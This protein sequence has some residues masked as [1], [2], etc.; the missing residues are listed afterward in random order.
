MRAFETL[1][2]LWDYCLFCP[3]CKENSRGISIRVGPDDRFSLLSVTP[4]QKTDLQLRLHCQYR[5]VHTEE[6][7]ILTY[8]I[9]CQSNAFELEIGDIHG[10]IQQA[11]ADQ[12]RRA[13]F[14]YY[15]NANCTKCNNAVAD[16][17]DV[18]FD[19]DRKVV[20]NLQIER[21]GYYL[22]S[23]REQYHITLSHDRNVVMVSRF[24]EGAQ[25]LDT[26]AIE[27]PFFEPN[28][29]DISKAIC[30]IKTLLLFS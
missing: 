6:P 23:E 26:R 12:A 10:N 8:V 30:R 21:E 19:P 7:I 29:S 3:L 1:Q 4:Y 25:P 13:Y 28:V 17:T 20:Y 16:T 15:L 14:Y 9:D 2:Q 24:I 18:E 27:L 22:A 5:S 11:L